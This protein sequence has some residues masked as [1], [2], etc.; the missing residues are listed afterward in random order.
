MENSCFC[1]VRCRLVL[2]IL[3]GIDFVL[4]C[5]LIKENGDSALHI[6]CRRRDIDMAR[7]LIEAGSPVDLRNVSSIEFEEEFLKHRI[8]KF[9]LTKRSNF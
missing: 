1:S 8:R 5:I 6:A 2:I 3:L 7:M 4:Q 9:L